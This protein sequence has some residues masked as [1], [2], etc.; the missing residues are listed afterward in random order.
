ML[1]YMPPKHRAFVAQLRAR[2]QLRDRARR[3]SPS[4]RE[5]YNACIAATDELRRK[6]IGITSEYILKQA[7]VVVGPGTTGTG[8]TDLVEFLR[9]SRIETARSELK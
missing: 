2:S 7:S 1:Q 5:I 3:G 4:L 6:H 8:G 9:E